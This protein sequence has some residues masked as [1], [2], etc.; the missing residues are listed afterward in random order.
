MT[1]VTIRIP[2]YA[3]ISASDILP[4]SS[5]TRARDAQEE[6]DTSM[7]WIWWILWWFSAKSYYQ[8]QYFE[9]LDFIV[10][11]IKERFNQPGYATYT[12]LQDLLLKAATGVSYE[13]DLQYVTNFYG[14]DLNKYT[15]DTQLQ[16][17]AT[18]YAN[19]DKPSAGA[20]PENLWG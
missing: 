10:S 18:L 4:W 11:F 20:D 14:T 15:L 19:K 8:Q 2:M 1:L 12:R 6:K 3:F 9:V 5:Y 16:M 7:V 13:S 17:L